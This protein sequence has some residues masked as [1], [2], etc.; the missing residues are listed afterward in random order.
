MSASTPKAD[1]IQHDRD[2]CF[3][4]CGDGFWLARGIF[5][6]QAYDPK[7]TFQ[8]FSGHVPRCILAR[9]DFAPNDVDVSAQ[10]IQ[11]VRE[12]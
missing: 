10:I 1:M 4:P 3:V 9:R 11:L 8:L 7:R 2:V 5:T 6:S 12:G